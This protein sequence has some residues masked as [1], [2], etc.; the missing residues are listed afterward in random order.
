METNELK[1]LIDEQEIVSI[2]FDEFEFEFL[3]KNGLGVVVG[4]ATEWDMAV[5]CI[6][7]SIEKAEKIRLQ[8]IRKQ[9]RIK[10]EVE[11]EAKKQEL[12]TKMS[13]EELKEIV[14]TFGGRI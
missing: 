2:K 9:N 13:E 3:F 1:K 6:E 4:I 5:Y 8:E 14:E 12:L 10:E 7:S 11:K